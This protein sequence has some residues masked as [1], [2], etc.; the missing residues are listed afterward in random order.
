[1]QHVPHGGFV[2]MGNGADGDVPADDFD[3]VPLAQTKGSVRPP[4]SRMTMTT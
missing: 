1:M 2:G 4:R 3:A